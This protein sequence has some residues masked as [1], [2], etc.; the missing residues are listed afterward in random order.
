M[1]KYNSKKIS[2]DFIG[3]TWT[4]IR[5]YL[6]N[7]NPGIANG[8]R[9]IC[10]LDLEKTS[11]TMDIESLQSDDT[12]IRKLFSDIKINISL[13]RTDLP[14]NIELI[15]SEKNDTNEPRII[16]SNDFKYPDGPEKK[17]YLKNHIQ[18]NIQICSLARNCSI[19]LTVKTEKKSGFY[20]PQFIPTRD[21]G[22]KVTDYVDVDLIN[23][24]GNVEEAMVSRKSLEELLKS[25]DSRA[26][27][28]IKKRNDG[29]RS[30]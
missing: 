17:E 14:E 16:T 30:F 4:K 2:A 10:L 8:L 9:R 18:Q 1:L 5:L 11:L 12:E 23:Y 15:I 29:M 25:K 6:E 19:K 28:L 24:S 13:I 20:G 22:Y 27:K 21:I 26:K 3:E 7:V